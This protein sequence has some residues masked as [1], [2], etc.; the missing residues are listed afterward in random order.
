MLDSRALRS[1]VREKG[2][3]R[4]SAWNADTVASTS[5][6]I[7][8]VLLELFLGASGGSPRP[9]GVGGSL[10]V[11]GI[12]NFGN[13]VL[14]P[15]LRLAPEISKQTEFTHSTGGASEQVER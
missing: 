4:R 13:A 1:A 8:P 3:V 12:T 9:L 15:Q 7:A 2:R 14:G 6:G 11:V 5:S 10:Q